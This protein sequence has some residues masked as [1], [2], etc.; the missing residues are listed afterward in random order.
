MGAYTFT[1]APYLSLSPL[2][3]S[4]AGFHSTK[5]NKHLS[6][7]LVVLAKSEQAIIF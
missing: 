3:Y 5:I 4:I 1:F 6:Y 7:L 2:I